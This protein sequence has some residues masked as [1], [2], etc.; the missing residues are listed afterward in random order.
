M[1]LGGG[2]VTKNKKKAGKKRE[3]EVEVVEGDGDGDGND[4]DDDGLEDGRMP[5]LDVGPA[6]GGD[7]N[8]M[9][10]MNSQTISTFMDEARRRRK[11]MQGERPMEGGGRDQRRVGGS[12]MEEERASAGKGG[13]AA[14]GGST[15]GGKGSKA[16]RPKM[17]RG[18]VV[19]ASRQGGAEPERATVLFASTKKKGH[20]VVKFESDGKQFARATNELS[21]EQ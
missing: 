6:F 16:G 14:K 19:M 17:T 2:K 20:W 21:Q 9:E 5:G 15:K 8:D 4:D 13:K 1:G 12:A 3:R 10:S 11:E 7:L 18:N